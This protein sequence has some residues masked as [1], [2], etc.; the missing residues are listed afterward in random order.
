MNIEKNN[1]KKWI[2]ILALVL[3]AIV[4]AGCAEE[5]MP[6]EESPF[7]E[8]MPGEEEQMPGGEDTIEE[9]TP[10]ENET[11]ETLN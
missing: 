4:T 9:E 8:G 6:G 3:V 10:E 5:G 7:E 2:P 1:L 11:D